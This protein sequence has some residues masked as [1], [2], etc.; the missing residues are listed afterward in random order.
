MDRVIPITNVKYT[1]N[2]VLNRNDVKVVVKEE[3]LNLLNV[4]LEQYYI[5]NEGLAM[6]AQHWLY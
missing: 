6:G 2:E 3:I 5:Q 1:I 4:I